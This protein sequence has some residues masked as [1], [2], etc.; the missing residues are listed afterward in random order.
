[1]DYSQIVLVDQNDNVLGNEEKY[2]A[3]ENPSKL[4][5]AISVLIVNDNHEMLITKR[6]FMKK[7]CPGFLT[8]S[9]CSHPTVGESYEAA[10]F[11]R[12]HE[13]LNIYLMDLKYLYTSVYD[14]ILDEKYGEHELTHVF[15]GK[16]TDRVENFNKNEVEEAF[17]IKLEELENFMNKNQ[18]IIT[19]WF[20]KILTDQIFFKDLDI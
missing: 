19:P 1:M 14:F 9:V 15:I 18:K 10:A 3:H 4:H 7:T 11:R 8:N 17:W 20:K 13:E 12:V 5:R 16:Y 2:S 6:A